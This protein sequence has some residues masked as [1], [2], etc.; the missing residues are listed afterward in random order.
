MSKITKED[1]MWWSESKKPMQSYS[2]EFTEE[3]IE[4]CRL[5]YEDIE[6]LQQR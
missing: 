1:I 4:T 6:K 5:L 2:K 3:L